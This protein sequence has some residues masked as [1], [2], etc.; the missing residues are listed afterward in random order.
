MVAYPKKDVISIG[1][2]NIHK[3]IG[4]DKIYSPE[5]II[6]V[7]K[8]LDVDV[9]ALQETDRRFGEREGLLNIDALYKNTQLKY[10]PIKPTT[11][12][13][14][15]WH[16]NALF[17]KKGR[18][19]H[20]RQIKLPGTESRGAL[21][22]VLD[23]PYCGSI[24]FIAAHFGLLRRDRSA[25]GKTLL[26]FIE[27]IHMPVILIGDLNEWRMGQRSSLLSMSGFFDV[28]Q[29]VQPSFPSRFPLFALDRILAYPPNLIAR[30][31]VHQSPLASVSSDH[32][33]IKAEIC[34]N[35]LRNLRKNKKLM[36]LTPVLGNTNSNI[37]RNR[38]V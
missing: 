10:L 34:I 5:R 12:S 11:P 4:I 32:L 16:G 2:Y 19:R 29:H 14:V 27:G 21:I 33:P 35:T 26:S 37:Q 20:I 28:T 23:L 6:N 25:Q 15:G 7:I 8:E 24:C 36:G 38:K 31:Y 22:V 30:L 9:L 17:F 18:V 13:G 3:C 1:S